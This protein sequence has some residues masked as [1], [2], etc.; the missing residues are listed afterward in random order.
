MSI[1][2]PMIDINKHDVSA[3]YRINISTFSNHFVEMVFL[4]RQD[5]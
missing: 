4:I 3:I 5:Q 1:D 2:I